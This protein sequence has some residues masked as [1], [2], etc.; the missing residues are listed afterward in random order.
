MSNSKCKLGCMSP[1][2]S[3]HLPSCSPS[4]LLPRANPL[5]KLLQRNP[6]PHLQALFSWSVFFPTGSALCP[7]SPRP[8]LCEPGDFMFTSAS[9]CQKLPSRETFPLGTALLMWPATEGI[10]RPSCFTAQRLSGHQDELLLALH[11]CLFCLAGTSFRCVS[12]FSQ[13][14]GVMLTA[15]YLVYLRGLQVSGSVTLGFVVQWALKRQLCSVTAW[16]PGRKLTS[17]TTQYLGGHESPTALLGAK[18]SRHCH[19]QEIKEED[20][21]YNTYLVEGVC[22]LHGHIDFPCVWSE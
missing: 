14:S 16:C 15:A 21:C 19:H 12:V 18:P 6:H 22:Y 20:F 5:A 8:R 4:P 2:P 17:A 10:D 7:D 13:D 1:Q 9:L 3:L 11:P